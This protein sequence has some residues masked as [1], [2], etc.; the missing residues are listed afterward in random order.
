[1]RLYLEV[2][3]DRYQLPLAVADS[4]RELARMRCVSANAVSSA[5]SRMGSEPGRKMRF[6]A[7]ETDLTKEELV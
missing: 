5:V 3:R 7:V 2:T 4:P 6:V 1:M